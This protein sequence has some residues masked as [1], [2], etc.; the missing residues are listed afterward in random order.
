MTRVETYVGGA[1]GQERR[2]ERARA[3]T[4]CG[5][6]LRS[7]DTK[8]GMRHRGTERDPHNGECNDVAAKVG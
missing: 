7:S 8:W 1:T 3:Q 5:R 4:E 2:S 6:G